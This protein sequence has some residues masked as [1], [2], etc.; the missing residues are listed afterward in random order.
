ME[1]TMKKRISNYKY[2]RVLN[3]LYIDFH[4]GT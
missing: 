4:M 3:C 2:Y 1:E